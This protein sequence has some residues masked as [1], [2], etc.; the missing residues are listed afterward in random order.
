MVG[1]IFYYQI[2]PHYLTKNITKDSNVTNIYI[3]IKKYKYKYKIN[4]S[5]KQF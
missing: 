3:Y 5:L 1:Y 4:I 2:L